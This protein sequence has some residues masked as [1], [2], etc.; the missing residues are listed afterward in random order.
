MAACCAALRIPFIHISTDYVFDGEKSSPYVETDFRNPVSIYGKSKAEGEI[1]IEAAGGLWTIFRTAWVFSAHGSNFIKTMIRLGKERDVVSVVAD[2]W[3]RPTLAADIA[4][5]CIK[6]AA[7]SRETGGPLTGL[8]HLAGA[9]DA[10]WADV[11][12][13]VFS[14]MAR[15]TGKVTKLNRI[16][17]SDYPTPAKRPLNSRLDTT[18]LQI[19]AGWSPRPWRD[20]VD[21][22]LGALL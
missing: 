1:A 4:E 16:G 10:V 21:V 9:D 14:A 19:R 13:H 20:A 11:A 15:Q 2:Q 12:E 18:Q 5:L 8:H 7:P 22:C 3:G 17:T 6:A